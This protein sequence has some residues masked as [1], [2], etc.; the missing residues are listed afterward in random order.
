MQSIVQPGNIS[1]YGGR[2]LPCSPACLSLISSTALVRVGS[3]EPLAWSQST[4]FL[5]PIGHINIQAHE[6]H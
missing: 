3:A 4:F 1:L 2:N 6:N 5:I